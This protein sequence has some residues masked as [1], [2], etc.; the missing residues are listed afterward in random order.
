VC[1]VV[2]NRTSELERVILTTLHFADVPKAAAT[3]VATLVVPSTGGGVVMMKATTAGQKGAQCATKSGVLKIKIGMK[4]PAS[5]EPSLAH[6][7]NQPKATKALSPVSAST[8]KVAAPS[9]PA[10]GS[11]D[12]CVEICSMLGMM[13][14]TSSSSSES[15]AAESTPASPPNPD[16]TILSTVVITGSELLMISEMPELDVMQSMMEQGE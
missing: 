7:A 16:T 14:T 15:L 13:S 12:A 9:P 1:F 3:N 2:H 4:R 5:T 8:R 11:D 6:T 10:R